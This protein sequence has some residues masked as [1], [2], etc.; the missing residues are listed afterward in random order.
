MNFK[1]R[2]IAANHSTG[3]DYGASPN[4]NTGKHCDS[5]S[6][7]D[8]IFDDRLAHWRPARENRRYTG[9]INSVIST[10]DSDFWT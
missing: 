10:H 7:P 1:R 3:G 4:P 2:Y 6:N 8:V 9:D 5:K